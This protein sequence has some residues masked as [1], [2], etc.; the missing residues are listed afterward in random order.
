MEVV[1]Y[2]KQQIEFELIR[3]ARRTMEIAVLPDSSVVV[4]APNATE[5][6]EIQKRVKKRARWIVQQINWFK[7]FSERLQKFEN[8]HI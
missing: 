7:Q 8:C 1:Q 5:L 2:G 3:C 4:K 6:A